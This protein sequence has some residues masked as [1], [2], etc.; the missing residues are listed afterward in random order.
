MHVL[1]LRKLTP[2]ETGKNINDM[3]FLP[4]DLPL[5]HASFN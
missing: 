4:F 3:H 5:R 2:F 1:T